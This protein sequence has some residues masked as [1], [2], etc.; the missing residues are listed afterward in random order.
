M[1]CSDAASESITHFIG[2]FELMETRARLRLDYD[3]LAA[4]QVQYE[5]GDLVELDQDV[6]HP[7]AF[8]DIIAAVRHA[9]PP[10]ASDTVA[11]GASFGY[12]PAT[13]QPLLT[14]PASYRGGQDDPLTFRFGS[15]AAMP[16]LVM[17][18][19]GSVAV[20]IVQ[21][22]RLSDDDLL[23]ADRMQHVS[24][25]VLRAELDGLV[26]EAGAL[27]VGSTL[28]LPETEADFVEMAWT[29]LDLASPGNGLS[30]AEAY[31]NHL[32][33]QSDA[34]RPDIQDLLPEAVQNRIERSDDADADAGPAHQVVHGA[35]M[36]VNEVVL[37]ASWVSAPVM[38]VGGDSISVDLISQVNVWQDL[39][40]VTG[41]AGGI[42]DCFGGETCGINHAELVHRSHPQAVPAQ[43]DDAA[44]QFWAVT[45]IE[46]S[47]VNFNWVVQ[48][49]YVSDNDVTSITLTASSTTLVFGANDAINEVSLFELG[50]HF[51]LIV[52]DGNLINL[53]A[54]FQT[55]VLLDSDH[56]TLRDAEGRISSGDNLLVNDASILQVGQAGHVAATGDYL[57]LLT[58]GPDAISSGVLQDGAFAGTEMLRV[59]HI[60]GDVVSA[61]IIE[62]INVL[63]DADQVDLLAAQAM[64]N[65]G[66]VT[67]VTGS[68]VLINS[69]HIA[70]YGVDAT[71]H[72]QGG[73]YTDALIHQ[74]ELVDT[75]PPP[76]GP[77]LAS[78]A[79][80]F[81][82][83]AMGQQG[84]D[85]DLA[86]HMIPQD[87]I[88]VDPM[89]AVLS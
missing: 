50:F 72:T 62:Q 86:P 34:P 27:G 38:V 2:L 11:N 67:V 44:P 4:V 74:A 53:A 45:T 52:I 29:A 30:G 7:Y 24:A 37:T 66:D 21:H 35:N 5:L 63:G 10:L 55:N 9:P 77:G 17:P 40:A 26:A 80:V 28:T 82:A 58:D 41:P 12:G 76:G 73:V 89:Q 79:V 33:G 23:D 6:P 71:V 88:P 3:E 83:D 39:D 31:G 18:A 64:E 32:N 60:K 1:F 48:H 59:L 61:Q 65:A 43:G 70:E 49:N 47:L 51:D 13:I 87:A 68:N 54:I 22:L 20:V 69:A 15:D 57:K 16:Q 78:E 46:G 25:D 14:G 36:L 56:V 84:D 19:P 85:G 42:W 75:A 8:R 81:L